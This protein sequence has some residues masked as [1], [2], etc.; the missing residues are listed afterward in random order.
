MH[1]GGMAPKGP[2][3]TMCINLCPNQGDACIKTD[4]DGTFNITKHDELRI[5]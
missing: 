3:I 1:A 4:S 5:H 2:S